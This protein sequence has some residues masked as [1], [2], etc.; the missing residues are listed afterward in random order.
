MKIKKIE[1]DVDFIGGQG[2]LTKEEDLAISN[3]IR[4]QKASK[5]KSL[6]QRKGSK[7]RKKVTA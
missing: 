7:L 2:P 3:F 6:L 4:A 1:L 5:R